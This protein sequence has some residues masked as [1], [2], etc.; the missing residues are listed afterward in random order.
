MNNNNK[1]CVLVYACVP[2]FCA[3]ERAG[4]HVCVYVRVCACMYV[5][6]RL[7]ECEEQLWVSSC[8]SRC[9]LCVYN[10]CMYE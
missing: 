4:V 6:A 2:A 7:R 10:E 5:C 8:L 1:V 9:R 3:C